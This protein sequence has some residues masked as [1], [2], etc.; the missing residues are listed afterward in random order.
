MKNLYLFL[1]NKSIHFIIYALLL[2]FIASGCSI[3]R[4]PTEEE[5]AEKAMINQEQQRKKEYEKALKRHYNMQSDAT[6]A[7][8]KASRKMAESNNRGFKKKNGKCY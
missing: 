7:Q 4:K 1:K 5:R 3:F 6:T 8:M 2:S